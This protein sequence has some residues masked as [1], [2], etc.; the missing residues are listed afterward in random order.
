[1]E[2]VIFGG[3]DA[4]KP[5]GAAEVRLRLSGVTTL[6]SGNGNGGGARANGNGHGNGTAPGRELADGTDAGRGR[7]RRVP[8]R[9]P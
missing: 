8:A 7:A 9:G 4:R 6:P 1:M 2:D 3:S 5:T